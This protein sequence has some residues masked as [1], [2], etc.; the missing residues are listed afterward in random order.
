MIPPLLPRRPFRPVLLAALLWA[1]VAEG[2]GQSDT[3]ATATRAPLP[4]PAATLEELRTRLAAHVTHPRFA[5]ALWG[6]QVV[7]LDTGRTIFE[8]E[9]QLRLSPASN[10]KLYAGALALDRL[11]GDYRIVTPLLATAPVGA[12]GTVDGDV[13]VSGRGDPGWNPRREKKDFWTAFAPFVAVLRQAGVR[14]INGDLVA[15]ATWLRVLPYG[16]G[17]TAD[18][19]GDYY[20]AEVSAVTIEE[21]YVDLLVTPAAEAGQPCAVEVRQPLSGLTI[22]NRTVTAPA[23][24][25]RRLRV[26]RL[27]GETRVLLQGELPV[28]GKPEET[29][30]TVP[31]P[32]EWFAVA[33][34]E[35]LAREGIAVGGRARSQRWPEPSVESAAQLGEVVSA[36]LRDLLVTIMKPSQNLKTDLV[37]AHL[38]ELRRTAATPAW[39]QSD[40]LAVEALGEFLARVGVTDG[41]VIFEE[42]S[43]LSRNN[44]TTAAATVRLL[45]FMETHRE[46]AAFRASLPVAGVDGSL[47]RRMKGTPA[48]GNAQA[49]TGSLRWANTLS[50]F[51]TTAAG[52]RLVFSLMLNRHRA[53]PDRANREELDEMVV[54]LAGFLGRS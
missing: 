6:V 30:A 53:P 21:N 38:G 35:A 33:L 29:E 24:A 46:G 18:D 25:E 44:L 9:P 34:R 11:G 17:W 5:G 23:G 42:G 12:D 43:G 28:G 51:V 15:D 2:T 32:A 52:E 26:L 19:L 13:V 22:D 8:H 41:E 27:P 47:R 1:G 10:S 54:L 37:F 49:K 45:R 50:G 3:P 36:P 48:E 7:S 4:A 20:G 40:E 14:R 16:A 39:R 31:R